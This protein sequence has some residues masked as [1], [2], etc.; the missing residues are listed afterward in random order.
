MKELR[1]LLQKE[2]EARYPGEDIVNDGILDER[3]FLRQPQ[4][5]M[6]LLKETYGDYNEIIGPQD[7]FNGKSSPFWPNIYNWTIFVNQ[8]FLNIAPKFKSKKEIGEQTLYVDN[9]AYVNVKKVNS[10]KAVSDKK[11]ILKFAEKDKDLLRKQIDVINPDIIF[12]SNTTFEA[13]QLIFDLVFSDFKNVK[14]Y[15]CKKQNFIYAEHQ[16]RKII[17]LYHPSSFAL[18]QEDT[19]KILFQLLQ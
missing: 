15:D 11:D 2:L 5:V 19:A 14:R 3:I 8:I 6:F 7:I 4:K 9:I 17:K 10:N 12:T 13:Y 16:H 18:T 1:R